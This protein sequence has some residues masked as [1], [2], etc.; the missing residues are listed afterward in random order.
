MLPEQPLSTQASLQLIEEMIGKAKRSY[1]S[2]GIASMVWGV[3]IVACSLLTWAQINFDVHLKFDVWLLVFAALIPQV[4]FGIKEKQQ[5]DFVS[6]DEETIR[7][8]WIAF[9]L[10]IFILSFYN[11]KYG[12]GESTTLFMMLYGIPTFITGGI[13]K[14]KPMIFGG[15]LCWAL[16]ILSL[17]SSFSTNMLLMAVCG[18]F[19]WLI[20]GV[21]LWNRYQKQREVHV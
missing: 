3:L 2:R 18:L 12:G 9:G 8:V 6:H 4:Y 16:S 7:Y 15:L 21:I 17:Y 11:S 13:A 5:K 19:A 14:F 20:S 10:S 1:I